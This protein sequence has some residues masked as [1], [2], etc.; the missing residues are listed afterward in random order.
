MYFNTAFPTGHSEQGMIS[1]KP[2][3]WHLFRNLLIVQS[4]VALLGVRNLPG[5]VGGEQTF[6]VERSERGL[7]QFR[8][9][10]TTTFDTVTSL[11]LTSPFALPHLPP[12]LA[13]TQAWRLWGDPTL[14]L[15][16][17]L[18][19]SFQRI[20][21]LLATCAHQAFTARPVVL[22]GNRGCSSQEPRVT[23][24][25]PREG[26]LQTLILGWKCGERLPFVGQVS[27]EESVAAF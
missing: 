19:T 14:V 25:V 20:K 10:S 6:P 5:A 11:M 15:Q 24:G 22:E 23:C 9:L 3:S 21:F 16:V 4:E 2:I 1:Q 7:G 8:P 18:G 12:H 27:I 13:W 26:G 17:C